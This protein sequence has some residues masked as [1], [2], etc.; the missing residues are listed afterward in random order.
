MSEAQQTPSQTSANPVKGILYRIAIMLVVLALASF[1]YERFVTDNVGLQ[2]APISGPAGALSE[3]TSTGAALLQRAFEQGQSN[4]QV[5]SVGVV[6]KV[7]ADD[8]QGSRHQRFIVQLPH[9]QT[10]LIPISIRI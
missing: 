3:E 2:A 9:G 6:T 4:L 8:N 10:V 1:A 5:Q 7:L